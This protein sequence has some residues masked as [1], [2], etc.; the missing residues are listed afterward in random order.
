MAVSGE[1]FA[2]R[3]GPK[4]MPPLPGQVAVG[5][6][7]PDF[8]VNRRKRHPKREPIEKT[9]RK[10]AS[11]AS[12]G[13]E[14]LNLLPY[15]H[16]QKVVCAQTVDATLNYFFYFITMNSPTLPVS[17]PRLIASIPKHLKGR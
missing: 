10:L 15:L 12:L 7:N 8:H 3:G 5:K 13:I 11:S 4:L 17:A 6:N 9:F 1:G 14:P 2:E 16:E